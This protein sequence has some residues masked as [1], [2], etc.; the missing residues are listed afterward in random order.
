MEIV[1]IYYRTL[2]STITALKKKFLVLSSFSRIIGY[3]S[4][5]FLHKIAVQLNRYESAV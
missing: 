5:N 4:P 3:I 2:Y 1:R